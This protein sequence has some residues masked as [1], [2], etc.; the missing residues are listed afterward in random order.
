MAKPGPQPDVTLEDILGVFAARTDP[1]E[2]LTATEIAEQ[3]DCSRRSVLNKLGELADRGDVVSKKVG[4]RS[5]VW[6]IPET[7]T[8]VETEEDPFLTAPTHEG[9]KGDVS[10]NVD[11]HLAAA[12]AGES[13]E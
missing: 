8:N 4:G 10:S 2:P 1:A 6:W 13:D 5:R 9:G 12:A 7:A 11:E 3:V